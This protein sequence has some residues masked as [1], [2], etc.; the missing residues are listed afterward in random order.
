MT[1]AWVTGGG[2]GIGRALA[3]QLVRQGA[4]VVISGRRKEV[5]AAA[6]HDIGTP[7]ILAIAGDAS[8][9]SDVA[10][11]VEK[12]QRR[13]GSID[14]LINN[15]GSNDN[16]AM[17]RT[18]AEEYQEAFE[19][20]CVSAILA[21]QAVL[22]E[23]IKTGRGAIVNIS[24]IYGRWA[25]ASSASYSVSKYALAGYTDVLRQALVRTNIHVMG[26]FPGFIR[27]DM[28][29]PFVAPGSLRE[30]VGKTPDQMAAAILR[31][32]RREKAEVYFPWYVLW[33]LRLHRWFPNFANRMAMKVKR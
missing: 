6:A 12:V 20:N 11:L 23:M 28:T 32:L 33:N 18:T 7:H 15:A 1:V 3:K 31:G 24:S 30:K 21:T 22:P 26:V 16:T 27:T 8:K 17:K 10:K 9:E 4:K 25:S 19:K 14:L 29:A 5:L 2:T 13:W